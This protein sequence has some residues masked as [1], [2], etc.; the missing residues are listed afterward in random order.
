VRQAYDDFAI[1]ARIAFFLAA[2]PL[3]FVEV[4]AIPRRPAASRNLAAATLALILAAEG[5][6][7]RAGGL[8]HFPASS[9]LLAPAWV[10]ERSL[11][12]WLALAA[13]L[14]GGV[15]YGDVRLGRSAT[16]SR[17]LRRRYAEGSAGEQGEAGSGSPLSARNPI[18]L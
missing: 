15:R 16:P 18:A 3:A 9:A 17:V 14:R 2:L 11:C 5:G 1:P 12:A 13:R 6:R 7:R 10:A 8:S 4:T